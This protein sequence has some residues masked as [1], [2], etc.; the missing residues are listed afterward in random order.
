M[1]GPARQEASRARAGV[2]TQR[3]IPLTDELL[4][5]IVEEAEAGFAPEQFRGPGRPRLGAPDGSGPSTVVQVRMDDD[6]RRRLGERAERDEVT[7]SEVVRA[8][9]RSHLT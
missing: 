8:A 3:G 7:V 5:A 1:R 9:L 6:L 2:P 4:D